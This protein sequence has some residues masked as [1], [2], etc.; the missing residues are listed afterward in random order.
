M[1]SPDLHALTLGDVFREN[2]RSWPRAIAAV[3]GGT[4]LTY[5][6]LDDRANRLANAFRAR[7]VGR[8]DRILWLGQNAIGILETLIAAAKI[9][10]IL[11][12]ANW[13]QSADEIGFILEDLTPGIVL[14]QA[15]DLGDVPD[16]ARAN[17]NC[18]A[19]WLQ[20]DGGGADCYDAFL[21]SGSADDPDVAVDPATPVLALYTAAFDGRPNAALL[22]QAGII[23]HNTGIALM[24]QIQPGFTYLN[25][26]PLFHVGTMFFCLATAHLGGKN[27]F[28]PKF[29]AAEACRLIEQ[30]R[31]TSMFLVPAM[32]DEM[33]AANAGGKFDLSSLE[34]MR[35]SPDWNAMVREAKS[36]WDRALGG[37]GQTEVAGM[38]TFLAL[39]AGGAGSHGRPSPLAQLRIFGPDETEMPIGEVGEIVARG[40]QMMVGYHNRPE[41]NAKRQ[42]G[43]WHHTGDLGRRETDG[44]ITFIG[45]KLRMIKSGGENI[46]PAEVE[47]CIAGHPAVAACA[48]IGVPDPRWAQS[49][50]AIVALKK[51]SAASAE[52]II[53]HCRQRIASY[54]KPRL[55]EF[56]DAIPKRGFTPDYDALDKAH[57]GGGYPGS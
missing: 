26:G 38:L 56:V 16:Q 4:R 49:V 36:P 31:C 17:T 11:C 24:R 46:Y 6:E 2:R 39:S 14:W 52:E 1:T 29:D 41:L 10:A 5:P 35:W 30:E 40:A 20:V 37:Y 3:D 45:P 19:L 43:G 55:V 9:G 54:K 53:E 33:V 34:A 8:G 32:I 47:R 48:V 27:V 7:G 44:T 57:G 28:M 22:S 23:A 25:S 50:K 51:D 21:D 15:R 13:R 18:D 42:A 12:P